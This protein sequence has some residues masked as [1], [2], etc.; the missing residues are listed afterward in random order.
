[1]THWLVFVLA[2]ACPAA[3]L[4]QGATVES[5]DDVKDV[6]E[7]PAFRANLPARAEVGGVPLPRDQG[8]TSSCVSW[9]VTYAA[10]SQAV[11]RSGL[12]PSAAL[13]TSF[14]YNQITGD[15]TCL[16]ETSISKTL[17]FLRENGALP[18]DEFAFDAGSCARLPTD[19]ERKRAQ[20]YRIKSWSRIDAT[21][22]DAVKGQ[23]ARGVPIIFAMR[24]GTKL[25]GHRGDGVIDSDAGDLGG[26]AMIA[27]G[28]DDARKAIRVQNSWGRSW[29]DG[30]YGWF[31][32]EFWK[33]NVRV[34]FVID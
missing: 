4:A 30:G 1:M 24:V 23:L 12:A 22:L 28:Y 9:A 26:H 2:L 34:G 7:P 21:D 29:A 10:G 31:A 32:Y 13:S 18:L 33:R 11:R 14:T 15:R 20:R 5:L 8:D 16:S 25:R 3:A 17:D 19:D 6:G 27:V